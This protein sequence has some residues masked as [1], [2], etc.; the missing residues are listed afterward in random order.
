VLVALL[1]LRLEPGAWRAGSSGAN[2]FREAVSFIRRDAVLP[3]VVLLYGA[4]LFLG[5]SPALALPVFADQ[6]LGLDARQLG[7]L[8][9]AVGA[10]TVVSALA[11]ASMGDV[12]H[13][14]RL[15]MG[16]MV[17]WILALVAFGASRTMMIAAAA[18][19]ALGVAQNAIGASALTLLQAR[20]P[21]EMR[22]RAMSINT[23]LIMC[24]RPMGDFPVGA[25]ITLL[26]FRP[27]VFVS[28]SLIAAALAAFLIMRPSLRRS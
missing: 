28:A 10:G 26:G 27:A 25:A 20:V 14:V 24:V 11:V 2:P 8:F 19:F 12:R 5:P 9:S 22:G 16:A 7:L 17:L 18:L 6:V 15:L 23:L 3:A 13:K 21:P 1:L 4:L